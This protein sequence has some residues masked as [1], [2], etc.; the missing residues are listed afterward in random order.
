MTFSDASLKYTTTL[1]PSDDSICYSDGLP[2]LA[3]DVLEDVEGQTTRIVVVIPTLDAVPGYDANAWRHLR[4]GVL[5][6][7]VNASGVHL[8]HYD[9]VDE[10]M[11]LLRRAES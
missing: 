3:G 9:N 2:V 10:D 4:T 1:T 5:V 11:E 8:V 7:H 6:E